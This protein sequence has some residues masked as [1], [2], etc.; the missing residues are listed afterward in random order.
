MATRRIRR[1][2]GALGLGVAIL[3]GALLAPFSPARLV[4]RRSRLPE[5]SAAVVA[6]RALDKASDRDLSVQTVRGFPQTVRGR[7]KVPGS[8]PVARARSYLKKYAALYGIASSKVALNARRADGIGGQAVTFSQTYEGL[9]V[10]GASLTVTTGGPYVYATSGRFLDRDVADMLPAF[11][12]RA[13]EAAARE[14]SNA[15]TAPIAGSTQ[16]VVYD[17]SVVGEGPSAPRLAWRVTLFL[18]RLKR[19]IVDANTRQVLFVDGI[20]VDDV[21]F[22]SFD[23]DI[24]D[25]ENDAGAQSDSCFWTSDEVTAGDEDGVDSDYQNDDDVVTAYTGAKAIYVQY[26]NAFG[27]HSYDD[28]GGQMEMYFHAVLPADKAPNAQYVVCSLENIIQYSDDFVAPDVVGHEWTHAV[29]QYSSDLSCCNQSG[30]LNESYADVM[31]TFVDDNWLHGEALLAGGGPSRNL[32]DPPA[33]GD[34]DR[35]STMAAMSAGDDDSGQVHC[36]TGVPNKAHFLMADGGNFN[37]QTVDGIGKTKM[38]FLAYMSIISMGSSAQFIDARNQE[39]TFA[40]FFRDYWADSDYPGHPMLDKFIPKGY[41]TNTVCNV[42]RAWAA[43]EVGPGDTDCDGVDDG[44][45]DSDGD[46]VLDSADNCPGVKAGTIADLDGDGKGDACD[47]DKDGDGVTE[48]PQNGSIGD[49]CPDLANADQKDADHDGKGEACD[50][51]EDGDLDNDGVMDDKDNCPQDANS[52]QTDD[53][54][55]GDGN[56]C[57]PDAD[58]DKLSNDNDN[59]AF[60][61]NG[62]QL[63]T[64]GDGL[65]DACDPCPAAADSSVAYS[66]GLPEL[67]VDPHPLPPDGDGDGT[68]DACDPDPFSLGG[69]FL[70]DGLPLAGDVFREPGGAA[71]ALDSPAKPLSAI[72]IPLPICGPRCPDAYAPDVRLMLHCTDP[73]PGVRMWVGDD[74]GFAVG[75]PGP[76]PTASP[77]ASSRS[78]VS[79]TSSTSRSTRTCHPMGACTQPATWCRRRTGTRASRRPPTPPARRARRRRRRRRPHRP[80]RRCSRPWCPASPQRSWP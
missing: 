24:E 73:G 54:H 44:S 16:L 25:A 56:A 47:P 13:A 27:R 4:G 39:V 22:D 6:L 71:R 61:S 10:Y 75:T 76:R 8:S 59:C 7:V 43:V 79:T 65:G 14:Q 57:D 30:A 3:A 32:G 46:G 5:G 69:P 38:G 33:K 50:P 36:K 1:R 58:G 78:S 15:P 20:G 35:L 74:E 63:D 21:G 45:D 70:Y 40:Q 48:K 53:D 11:D 26:H 2:V 12:A 55:D 23:L 64:D 31:S 37:G 77:P 62:D 52:M 60:K 19:V 66:P 41:T 29:V 80:A 68:P 9:T 34:P 72:H 18:D 51:D 42:I 67:G 49:N 28:D 17:P